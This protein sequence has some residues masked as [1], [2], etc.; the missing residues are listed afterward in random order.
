MN[1]WKVSK[2]LSLWFLVL[3]TRQQLKKEAL[4]DFLSQPYIVLSRK[5]VHIEAK[6]ESEAEEQSG[7]ESDM[8]NYDVISPETIIH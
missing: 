4:C 2:G 8:D 5:P 3:K 6:E 7:D 1:R